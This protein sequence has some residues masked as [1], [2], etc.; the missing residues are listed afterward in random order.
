MNLSGLRAVAMRFRAGSRLVQN[1]QNVRSYG[2]VSANQ[3]A[4]VSSVV[5]RGGIRSVA[6]IQGYPSADRG[7]TRCYGDK[8][9]DNKYDPSCIDLTLLATY[10]DIVSLPKHPEILLIDVRRPEEI[11]G[12]GTIPTSINIPLSIVGEE[13]QLT[14]KDFE[15][16]YGRVKPTFCSPIIFSCRSGVR[17][18]EAANIADK[19][20][21]SKVKNYVGSWLE[22][23]EK[24]GLPLEPQ[25]N[26]FY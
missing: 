18:G 13:L 15:D 1:N 25:E 7:T 9:A 21:F 24:N 20:G 19:L 26:K 14:A 2:V 8:C 17:A 22:Y 11:A 6:K 3:I 23:A 5:S 16:R 4:P 10:D 12:T